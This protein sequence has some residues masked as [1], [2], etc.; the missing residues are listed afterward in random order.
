MCSSSYLRNSSFRKGDSGVA[1]IIIGPGV[2]FPTVVVVVV[3]VVVAVVGK[4]ITF[5]DRSS[6]PPLQKKYTLS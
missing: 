3:V 1:I 4:L 6:L 2:V 5:K